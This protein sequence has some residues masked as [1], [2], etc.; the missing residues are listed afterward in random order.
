MASQSLLLVDDNSFFLRIAAR[1]LDGFPEIKL[2]DSASSA[3]EALVKAEALQPD[4][5]LLDLNMPGGS[6]LDLLP[7]LRTLAPHVRIVVLTLWDSDAYRQAALAAGADDFVPKALI[8]SNLVPAITGALPS[9]TP[10]P[11]AG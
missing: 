10:R 7:R 8:N 11:V 1:F 2:L 9:A 6:G 5:I 4:V 3:S